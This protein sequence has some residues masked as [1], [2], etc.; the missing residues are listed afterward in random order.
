MCSVGDISKHPSATR[1]ERIE[2]YQPPGDSGKR[3]DLPLREARSFASL[4]CKREDIG[5]G[6]EEERKNR[7]DRITAKVVRQQQKD[8]VALPRESEENSEF[9]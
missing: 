1:G 7:N 3:E 2:S 8:P 6:K 5:E 9:N 4:S